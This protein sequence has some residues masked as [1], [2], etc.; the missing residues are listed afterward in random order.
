MSRIVRGITK[1]GGARFFVTESREIVNAAIRYHGTTPTAT[2]VLGRV[3]TGASL[4]GCMLK[5]R[6]DSLTLRFKGDGSVGTVMAVSDDCGCV[7]GYIENPA[8]DF[9][10]RTDGKLDVGRAIGKGNVYVLKDEGNKEPY[11][12]IS[13]IVSGEIAEDIAYYFASSEQVPT[14]CALGVLVDVDRTC[15]AAGGIIIQTLPFADGETVSAIEKNSGKI[16]SVS[17][18][19]A[20]GM[21]CEDVA[22][23][24]LEGVPFDF[25]DEIE[26]RYFC[27]C[28]RERM[29]RGVASL[30][31]TDLD[32]IFS[33][34]QKAEAVCR[35]CG[36]KYTFAREELKNFV[37]RRENKQNNSVN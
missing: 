29:G 13:E 26:T 37:T 23:L 30:P 22:A 33:D 20:S 6:G 7:K 35:F 15:K 5:N 16:S 32:E 25:F 19:F 18:L 2:A 12:G 28:S 8:V 31:E 14:L 36:K 3:L 34:G 21:R 4:M 27:D 17:S 9:P 10:L 11:I 24:A 1:D